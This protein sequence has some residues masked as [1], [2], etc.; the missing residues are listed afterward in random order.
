MKE[1]PE[2]DYKQHSMGQKGGARDP[3]PPSQTHVTSKARAS[4]PQVTL[5]MPA[6]A[7][8]LW[9]AQVWNTDPGGYRGA[10]SD[11]GAAFSGSSP[12]S[13][14]RMVLSFLE[15]QKAG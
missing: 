1:T 10:S 7:Q 9:V 8:P 13:A 4:C 12:R 11:V 3:H 15:S 6:A 14:I 5:K 2:G